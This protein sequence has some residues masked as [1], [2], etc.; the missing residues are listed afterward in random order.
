[1]LTGIRGRRSV[2]LKEC[3]LCFK[4]HSRDP[5]RC[6]HGATCSPSQSQYPTNC[7]ECAKAYN[8]HWS[9]WRGAVEAC[10]EGVR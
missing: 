10:R 1:M 4:L 9:K 3:R 7:V 5:H 2:I 6:P 8:E